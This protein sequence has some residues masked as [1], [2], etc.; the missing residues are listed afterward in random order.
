MAHVLPIRLS[1]SSVR[2]ELERLSIKDYSK[3]SQRKQDHTSSFDAY[4]FGRM[5]ELWLKVLAHMMIRMSPEQARIMRLSST[6]VTNNS[7]YAFQWR[8]N[9]LMASL[10]E[11]PEAEK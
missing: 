11:A 5:K 6:R 3:F 9:S 10:G 7:L 8:V 2:I 4:A 1:I